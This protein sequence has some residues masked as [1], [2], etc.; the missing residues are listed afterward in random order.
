MLQFVFVYVISESYHPTRVYHSVVYAY[1]I[2]QIIREISK[3]VSQIQNRE[4]ALTFLCLQNYVWLSCS[5]S[6][7]ESSL[8]L[9]LFSWVGRV[10]YS[11]LEWWDQQTSAREEALA[12]QDH[13]ARG[14]RL[15]CKPCSPPPFPYLFFSQDHLWLFDH[16]LFQPML[17]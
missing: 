4:S 5:G 12:G 8:L 17:V 2:I 11:W 16:T 1:P 13:W 15:F 6:V 3:K 14:T 10:S 7:G 9:L